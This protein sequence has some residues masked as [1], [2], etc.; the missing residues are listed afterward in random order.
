MN[1]KELKKLSKEQLISLVKHEREHFNE[2]ID[3]LMDTL[4]QTESKLEETEKEL[5]KA[6]KRA[7]DWEHLWLRENAKKL[8]E[9]AKKLRE[10]EAKSSLYG[11]DTRIVP[12]VA[13]DY[14]VNGEDMKEL[15][16]LRP[17]LLDFF[18]TRKK[19]VCLECGVDI[20]DGGTWG[21]CTPCG[22]AVFDTEV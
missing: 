13:G 4:I 15:K 18:T 5:K 3:R 8:R 12:N 14:V 22:N 21:Y 7:E 9:N 2:A 19:D 6:R 11:K 10:I 1:D 20:F 16:R 17:F